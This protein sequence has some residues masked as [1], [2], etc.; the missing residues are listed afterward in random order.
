MKKIVFILLLT[1][2]SLSIC[3][4]GRRIPNYN[5]KE[6]KRCLNKL[7]LELDEKIEE[8]R[9]LCD[10]YRTYVFNKTFKKYG[11]KEEIKDK[12]K[13]CFKKFGLKRRMFSPSANCRDICEDKKKKGE[14]C[15]CP[16]Y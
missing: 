2:F 13:E 9:D 6:L 15:N 12:L 14:K 8:L 4:P 1:I 7:N 16:R 10:A 3:V 5:E 11:L